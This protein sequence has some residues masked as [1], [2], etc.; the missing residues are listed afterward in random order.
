MRNLVICFCT[1]IIAICTCACESNNDVIE[2][3]TGVW[4]SDKAELLL[5]DK[6]MMYF[7]KQSDDAVFGDA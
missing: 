5:T 1:L 4:V 7:E 3:Q 2:H 6:I